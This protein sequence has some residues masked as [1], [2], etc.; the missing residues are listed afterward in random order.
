MEF[1]APLGANYRL[2]D[3]LGRGAAGEVRLAQ[4]ARTGEVLAA[5]LLHREHAQDPKLVERFVRERSLLMNLHHPNVV[6]IHDLVVEGEQ[7]AIVMDY[8]DGGSLRDVLQHR[9]TLPPALALV[10]MS[11]VFDAM[12][13]AHAQGI[14]H[15]DIKPDNVLLEKGWEDLPGDAIKVSDFGIASILTARVRTTTGLLGTPEYMAPEM[16]T[17]GEGGAAADVYAAGVMLYE[18]LGGRTPFAGPGTDFAVAYRHVSALVPPLPV[19]E[20]VAS[21]LTGLLDKAP[22]N[23]P[24]ASQAAAALRNASAHCQNQPAL[25]PISGPEDFVMEERPATAVRGI[26]TERPA[27]SHAPITMG[28]A[29]DVGRAEGATMLRSM[30]PTRAPEPIADQ[31]EP[32]LVLEDNEAPWYKKPQQLISV[33]LGTVLVVGGLVWLSMT[34]NNHGDK[35]TNTVSAKAASVDTTLPSGLTV[36]RSAE[37]NESGGAV[38]TF[39]FSAQKAELHGPILQVIGPLEQGKPCPTLSWQG[40]VKATPHKASTTGIQATCGW[41]IDD[42][43]IHK[44]ASV[45]VKAVILPENGSAQ[46]LQKWLDDQATATQKA[47]TDA[48]T[49]S[50]AYPVQRLTDIQLI[51]P[52]RAVG[53]ETIRISLVPVWPSG[54]DQLNVLYRSPAMGEAST[55]LQTVGGENTVRFVDGCGGAVNVSADGLVVTA[56]NPNPKCTVRSSVGNFTDLTSP[57]FAIVPRGG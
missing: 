49:K 11:Q 12:A 44:G 7:L 47:I 56:V 28:E 24:T 1:T 23:R 10:V 8:M 2:G 25:T 45:T 31:P 48:E 51:V 21:L 40:D 9:R 16:I 43:T 14:I 41:S 37:S 18:L 38:L 27:E 19:S 15:R 29:P 30:T 35:P 55:M 3:T 22:A 46:D 34:M 57:E 32:A 50:V 53:G 26:V 20:E 13:A 33:I 6:A 39:T 17:T 4:D 52:K 36:Q 54:P 5:K 42:L